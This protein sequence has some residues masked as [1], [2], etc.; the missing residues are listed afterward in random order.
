M[1]RWAIPLILVCLFLLAGCA[2]N[3][4]VK[5]PPAT[6]PQASVPSPSKEIPPAPQPPPR[7]AAPSAPVPPPAQNQSQ[8]QA[9]ISGQSN[10]SNLTNGSSLQNATPSAPAKPKIQKWVLEGGE[11]LS[12]GVSP[13]PMRVGGKLV[14]YYTGMGGIFRAASDDGLNF[15]A[16]AKIFDFASNSAIFHLSD[17]RYRMLYNPML[18]PAPGQ[19]HATSQYF[20]SAVSSDGLNWQKED[21]VRFRSAGAPDYDTV[22]VPAV[23]DFG[24]N[25]L[26]MYFVGD[27]YAVDYERAG[28]NI[29][30]AVSRDGGLSWAREPGESLPVLDAMDPAVMKVEGGYRLYYTSLVKPPPGQEM[31]EFTMNVYS[32]FSP[33]GLKFEPEGMVLAAP[34][35][36]QRLMDPEFIQSDNGSWRMYVS[37]ATGEG[38]N[39]QTRLVSA[40]PAS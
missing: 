17:G 30:S 1:Q 6:P 18:P 26:R 28:N 25:T 36:G 37:L 33:D 19:R 10:L 4:E 27:M 15:G 14:L 12:E 39:E 11:R 32:A 8:P 22:S 5:N 35:A 16:P 7:P 20:L 13:S 29:R 34:A 23:V 2:Q 3:S 40:V 21:G 38:Q 24:N 31:K 9:N